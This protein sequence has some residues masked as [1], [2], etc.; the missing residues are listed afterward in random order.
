MSKVA[1]SRSGS[2]RKPAAAKHAAKKKILKTK[3]AVKPAAASLPSQG[4][5]TAACL[6]LLRRP[7]GATLPDLMAATGWQAHSVRGFLSGTVRRKMELTL[8]AEDGS[9]GVRRYRVTGA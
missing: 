6:G 7:D 1:S 3:E 2:S 8:V 9:D 5:K 4:S